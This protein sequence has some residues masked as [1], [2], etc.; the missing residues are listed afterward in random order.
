MHSLS[1]YR[2]NFIFI[3]LLVICYSLLFISVILFMAVHLKGSS[4]S[5]INTPPLRAS[6]MTTHT[7]THTHTH[8]RNTLEDELTHSCTTIKQACHCILLKNKLLLLHRLVS[9]VT[10]A[11]HSS[12]S[13]RQP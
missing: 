13:A 5:P 9:F 1:L 3:I 11:I 8:Y 4:S 6:G 2:V 7:H 10:D 12:L